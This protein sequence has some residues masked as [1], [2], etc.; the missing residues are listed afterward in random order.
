MNVYEHYLS[1]N[2]HPEDNDHHDSFDSSIDDRVLFSVK[3]VEE[4]SEALSQTIKEDMGTEGE[5]NELNSFLKSNIKMGPK[6]Q[7]ASF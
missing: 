4:A 2:A 3:S 1:A 5:D 6:Q 7:A